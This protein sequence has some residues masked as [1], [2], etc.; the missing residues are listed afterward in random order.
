MTYKFKRGD[1][2]PDQLTMPIPRVGT[3]KR[4]DFAVDCLLN[5]RMMGGAEG[6]AFWAF[7]DGDDE[8]LDIFT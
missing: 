6:F 3:T 7:V 2:G 4:F 1:Q 5:G 8:K